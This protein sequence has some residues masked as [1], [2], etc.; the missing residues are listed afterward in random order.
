MKDWDLKARID[1]MLPKRARGRS[2]FKNAL[3]ES[4]AASRFTEDSG[5]REEGN[6]HSEE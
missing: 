6:A 2:E 5:N 1:R 3:N 4:R